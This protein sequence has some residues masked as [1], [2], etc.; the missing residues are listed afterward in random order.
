MFLGYIGNHEVLDHQIFYAIGCF[1]LG[2]DRIFFF[3][4][5]EHSSALSCYGCARG[6]NS[7]CKGIL[8]A[9]RVELNQ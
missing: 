7:L 5:F 3:T 4:V 2:E 9:S 6:I 1:I 8:A